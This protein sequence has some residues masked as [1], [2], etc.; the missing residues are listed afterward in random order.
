MPKEIYPIKKRKGL[1][2]KGHKPWNT[3]LKGIHLSPKSEFKKGSGGFHGHHSEETKKK[4]SFTHK[5]KPSGVKGKHYKL[6]EETKRKLSLIKGGTGISQ[7]TRKRYYHLRDW[8]YKKWR[9][10]VFER[11]NWICQTCG[12]RSE[13]G[14]PIYLEAHHIKNWAKYPESRYEISNGITLCRECH[15]LVHK[16]G[17]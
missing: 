10:K 13:A 3:G 11:D 8:Q 17:K 16:Y 14:K 12:A 4:M 2:Q 15:K 5:G 6:S 7:I 1:F 9:S